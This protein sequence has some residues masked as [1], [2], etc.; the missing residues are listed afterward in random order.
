M[1]YRMMW[2]KERDLLIAQTMAFVQSVSGKTTDTDGGLESSLETLRSN[3]PVT[4]ARPADLL[5][6]AR[7]SPISHSDMRDEIQRRVAAFR[8]RQQ[9]FDRDRDEYCNA[10]MAKARA[11]TA[12]AVKASDKQPLKR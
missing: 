12:H 10:T 11:A 6:A 2:K 3:Q 8:V 7:L 1:G 5:P 4:V 9:L